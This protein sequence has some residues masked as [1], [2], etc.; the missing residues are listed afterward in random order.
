MTV[1][2]KRSYLL[3]ICKADGEYAKMVFSDNRGYTE[4]KVI[5]SCMIENT[6]WL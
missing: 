4:S 1:A 6:A 3:N 5:A 2:G